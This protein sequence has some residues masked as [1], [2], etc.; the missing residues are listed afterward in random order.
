[1]I[2]VLL[3]VFSV[4]FVHGLRGHPQKTWETAAVSTEVTKKSRGLS[5]LFKRLAGPSL[6]AEQAQGP[7]SSSTPS[8]A[9]FWPKEYLAVDIPQACVWTYGY[10]AD[11][12]GGLFQANNKT[13]I[14]QHGRD[15]SVRLEREID[16]GVCTSLSGEIAQGLRLT[17]VQKPLAFVVHS[18][19][20]IVLKDVRACLAIHRTTKTLLM[21]F[22]RPSVDRRWSAVGQ[23]SSSSWG[24]HTGAARTQIGVRS[25][26]TLP[27]LRFKILIRRSSRRSR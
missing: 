10:N 6:A 11:V 24:R 16:N 22:Y 27:A 26:L 15:L 1:M 12:I 25:L 4:V 9:V 8:P 23:S 7:S 21:C 17:M 14:S 5:S 18:L 19:G 20:G 13:S 3:T 2:G